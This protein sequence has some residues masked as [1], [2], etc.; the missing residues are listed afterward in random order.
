MKKI[1]QF[2]LASLIGLAIGNSAIA[3]EKTYRVNTMSLITQAAKDFPSCVEYCTNQLVLK[4]KMTIFGPVFFWTVNVSH[5]SPNWL[6]MTHTNLEE[7]PYNEFNVFFGKIYQTLTEKALTTMI[8]TGMKEIGTGRE[9]YKNFG[10]YQA[11]QSTETT[12][13]GHPASMILAMFDGGGLKPAGYWVGSGKDKY[14][15][16]CQ[17][18]GCLEEQN[19]ELGEGIRQSDKAKKSTFE[20]KKLMAISFLK[21]WAT[22]IFT[23]QIYQIFDLKAVHDVLATVGKIKELASWFQTFGEVFSLLQ[24]GGFGVG[25][26][27]GA[28]RVFCPMDITP[29]YPYYLSGIDALSWRGGYPV[30]DPEFSA[31]ILNPLSNDIIGTNASGLNERWGH[32]YPREGTVNINNTAK[33]AAVV[34]YR[35]NS[36]LSDETRS[37]I[38]VYKKPFENTIGAWSKVVPNVETTT[39]GATVSA[40]HKNIAN[41]GTMIHNDSTYA[42]TSWPRYSCDLA[43]GITIARIKFEKCLTPRVPE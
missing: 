19:T 42:W 2:I 38:R 26:G 18:H 32:I 33:V 24:N 16:Q 21:N 35:A 7:T 10:D 34:A 28:D 1:K 36:V 29:F 15:H 40:C 13:M 30:T 4:M 17:T 20:E 22:G 37:G 39:N 3:S 9:R 5:N 25:V 43:S 31:T 8:P 14:W 11:V 23:S 6:T 12:V 41:T 27:I